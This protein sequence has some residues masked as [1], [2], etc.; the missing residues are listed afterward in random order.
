MPGRL[1]MEKI[2]TRWNLLQDITM[3]KD[4]REAIGKA[5]PLFLF[6]AF[7]MM[8][9]NKFITNYAELK[10]KLNVS[11]N[12]LKDWRD[13]LVQNKVVQVFKGNGSNGSE[14][15]IR[16]SR[17]NSETIMVSV[18]D[19]GC[20]IPLQNLPKSFEHFFTSKTDGLGMGLS[21]SRS[22]VEAHG[23]CLEAENNHNGGAT[24]YFTI[25]VGV[26]DS[27]MINRKQIIYVVDDNISICRALKLLLQQHGFRVETFTSAKEFLAF[28]YPKSPSCL[29]AGNFHSD[30]QSSPWPGHVQ[31][32]GK[33]LNRTHQLRPKSG[34]HYL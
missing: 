8:R 26:K 18:K 17:K 28:K 7:N 25:P 4:T 19:S 20:G 31:D 33:K 11:P 27:V 9:A 6:L 2:M 5:W 16:T 15:L 32:A 13:H 14:M 22:I 3:A 23:G 10:E 29:K 24:F 34:H 30:N 12:T 21:I 1:F